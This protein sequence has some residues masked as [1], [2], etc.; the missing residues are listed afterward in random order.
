MGVEL[1]RVQELEYGS[2]IKLD[3]WAEYW[4]KKGN[5][6]GRLMIA[7]EGFLEEVATELSLKR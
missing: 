2:P 3:A 1:L 7:R 4:R 5:S 6:P